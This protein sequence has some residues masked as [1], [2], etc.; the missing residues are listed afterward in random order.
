M[1]D[2][3]DGNDFE[4]TIEVFLKCAD[5]IMEA[6][7]QND[8]EGVYFE[9]ILARY[10]IGLMMVPHYER[11]SYLG[12]T[13]CAGGGAK[14]ASRTRVLSAW[15]KFNELTPVLTKPGCLFETEGENI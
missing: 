14:E 5:M 9:R 8:R 6:E 1:L 13:L 10:K 15:G 11:C 2:V 12:D 4:G 3:A 7:E